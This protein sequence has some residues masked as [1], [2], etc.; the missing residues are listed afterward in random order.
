MRETFLAKIDQ[1]KNMH[2]F[3]RLL[4][5]PGSCAILKQWG[6]IGE[7]VVEDWEL[8]PDHESAVL[9]FEKLLKKKLQRG[10]LSADSSVMPKQWRRYV[11]SKGVGKVPR[12]LSF[13]V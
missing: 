7:Y 6:R 5:P 13:L 10:Y 3:Y 4:L 2:R 1:E 11:S 8:I 12:Q 9:L